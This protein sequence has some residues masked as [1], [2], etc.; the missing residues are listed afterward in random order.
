[1]KKALPLIPLLGM[2]T[3]VRARLLSA[4]SGIRIWIIFMKLHFLWCAKDVKVSPGIFVK[5]M[6]RK[7]ILNLRF[8]RYHWI[9]GSVVLL[10]YLLDFQ[11]FLNVVKEIALKYTTWYWPDLDANNLGCHKKLLLKTATA[12]EGANNCAF[13]FNQSIYGSS[14][15]IELIEPLEKWQ[16]VNWAQM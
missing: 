9:C 7:N 12:T 2:H 15:K 16:S 1:M 6:E 8:Q 10:D 5:L 11:H 4:R 13:G 3:F 14:S